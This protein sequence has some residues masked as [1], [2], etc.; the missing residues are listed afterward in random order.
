MTIGAGTGCSLVR[1]PQF[2]E[3]GS[4]RDRWRAWIYRRAFEAPYGQ[5]E[6]RWRDVQPLRQRKDGQ[7]DIR[8]GDGLSGG[9]AAAE[10]AAFGEVTL[11]IGP[12]GGSGSL[13]G[14]L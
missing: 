6:P 11:M 14:P 8:S 5:L 13:L 4:D 7:H 2:G 9:Y 1:P 10:E 12:G 3:N